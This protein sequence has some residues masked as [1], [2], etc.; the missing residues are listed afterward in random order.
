[1]VALTEVYSVWGVGGDGFLPHCTSHKM[2]GRCVY[3]RVCHIKR[4]IRSVS[5]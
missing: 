1:M 4:D 3:F 2:P 5:G